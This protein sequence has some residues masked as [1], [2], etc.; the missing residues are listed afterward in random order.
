MTLS[1][2]TR[3]ITWPSCMEKLGSALTIRVPFTMA[4]PAAVTLPKFVLF[5]TPI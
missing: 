4:F 3:L 1:A 2:V 5:T